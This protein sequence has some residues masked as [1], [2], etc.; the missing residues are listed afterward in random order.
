MTN[1]ALIGVGKWGANY[2]RAIKHIPDCRIAYV[3][4]HD[5]RRLAG[6]SDV[7]GVIVATPA[8][9]HFE[10]ARFFLQKNIHLLVEKPL[11]ITYRDALRLKMLYEKG[12][13]MVMVGHI[14]V[15]NP[16][17]CAFV[18]NVSTIG[19]IQYLMF[20][21]GNYGPFRKNTTALWDWG[22]HDISMCLT[23]MGEDPISV[24]AWGGDDM[25]EM[26]LD[27][28][29]DTSAVIRTGR[30]LPEKKKYCAAIGEKGNIVFDDLAENKVTR[31]T[32]SGSSHR[33]YPTYDQKEPL[34]EQLRYFVD[35]IRNQIRLDSDFLMG[36]RVV[37]VLDA[38]QQSLKSHGKTIQI[39]A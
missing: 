18:S 21:S 24:A 32:Y 39:I 22:P 27:F 25:I 13:S 1:L 17:F 19:R 30:L 15:H 23:I 12:S 11:A 4:T 7:D 3:C 37:G 26:R 31:Y 9:T 33:S 10:I 2:L 29:G 14:Y 6:N 8:E 36:V 16:A 28:S 34:V 5:Y 35:A 38:A 20:E